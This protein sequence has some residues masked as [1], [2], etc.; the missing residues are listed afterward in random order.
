MFPHRNIRKYTWTSLD[1]KIHNPV[2]HMLIDR[3]WQSSVLDIQSFK[4]ANSDTDHHLVVGKVR[5]RL[6]VNKQESQKFDSKYL[7]SGS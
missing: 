2:Y 1:G 6:A 3:R 7:T 5:K 4:G